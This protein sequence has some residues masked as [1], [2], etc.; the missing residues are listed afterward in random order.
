MTRA[1]LN[2]NIGKSLYR[3]ELSGEL[4]EVRE[5]DTYRWF[6]YGGDVVQAAID[7]SNRENILLPVPQSM[8]LFLL[9]Q[10]TSLQ[11]LNLGMGAGTI[12][13]ALAK[14][15]NIELTSV[16]EKLEIIEMAK[17]YFLSPTQNNII[18][19]N[20]EEFLQSTTETYDVILCDIFFQQ[21]SPKCLYK[22]DFYQNLLGKVNSSGSV[23]I[24]LFPE[25]KEN[26]LRVL[27]ASRAFFDHVTLIDFDDYQNIVLILSQVA[28]PNK[29]Q[30]ISWNN[31]PN[32]LSNISFKEHIDNM[33]CVPVRTIYR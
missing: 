31:L 27:T 20:A 2:A 15:P 13:N 17:Q 11:V 19:Q 33:Y 21:R 12:E 25:N 30:L 26:L 9:W 4:L 6:H 10:K 8:L 32:K 16:E 22:E 5:Q 7:T 14:L 24:N 28:L 3:T 18:H 29:A 23:F 1:I